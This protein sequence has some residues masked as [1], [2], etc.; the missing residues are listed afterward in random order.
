MVEKIEGA[1]IF[2]SHSSKDWKKVREIRNF[3]EEKGHNPLLFHLK[4]LEEDEEINEL[5]K[6]EMKARNWFV[7]CDSEN[8]QASKYVTNEINY[9]KS[10]DDKVFEIINLEKEIDQQLDKLVRL[11][12]RAT[13]Y[14]SYAQPDR[15]VGDEM[16]QILRDNDYQVFD[17]KE[18]MLAGELW[19]KRIKNEIDNA[20]KDG[21]FLQ[22]ITENSLN[23][24]YLL[25]E[26]NY[27]LEKSNEISE[28]GNIIPIALVEPSKVRQILSSHS[29]NPFENLS[30]TDFSQG[31][32][33]SNVHALIKDLKTRKMV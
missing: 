1:W 26:V 5:L 27:A 20:I 3:L 18:D 9:I 13:I 22:L 6:R 32:L 23:S 21:Y 14:L 16:I 28:G 33:K 4:C 29:N 7:L 31:E 2:V 24:K 15:T 25:D 30:I 8:A 19:E 12:K 11:S 17:V 10:L